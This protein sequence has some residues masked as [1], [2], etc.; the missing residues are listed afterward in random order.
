MDTWYENSILKVETESDFGT[1][2]L[3]T[4]KLA[5]TSYH[6]IDEESEDIHV[7]IDGKRIKAS[8][9]NTDE[10][11]QLRKRDVAI[12]ELCEIL[13]N[14]KPMSINA[15]E[16]L[17]KKQW[18]TKG[19]LK[20]KGSGGLTITPNNSNVIKVHHSEF[21]NSRSTYDLELLCNEDW[22][23]YNGMSG[24]PIV[25]DG[26][27]CGMLSKNVLENK[28]AKELLGIS[29]SSIKSELAGFG[30]VPSTV[31]P[32]PNVESDPSASKSFLNIETYDVR[33]FKEKIVSVCKDFPPYRLNQYCRLILNVESELKNYSKEQVDA[34]KY[35]IFETCQ[36]A[37][38]EFIES[39]AK[40]VLTTKEVIKQLDVFCDKA[41]DVIRERSKDYKYPLINRNSIK[42]IV[43][44][45]MDDC[46][47]SLD[48]QGIYN[49]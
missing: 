42:N 48:S 15:H 36:E 12:L 40:D 43:L 26:T 3:V 19:Y 44:L 5:L 28:R 4:E 39:V 18:E 38:M 32:S 11:C 8:L 16:N 35:H 14:L 49:E 23:K 33:N 47:L 25:V 22:D 9:R 1:A 31:S 20:S 10:E 41:H 21:D 13:P 29:I 17:R 46:F 24:S 34:L 45:M 27:A 30:I 7:H 37:L 6:I 2:F